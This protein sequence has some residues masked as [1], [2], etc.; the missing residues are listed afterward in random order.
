MVNE[1]EQIEVAFSIDRAE[2]LSVGCLAPGVDV[3]GTSSGLP[4]CLLQALVGALH[5]LCMLQGY[6]PFSAP[7]FVI[8]GLE[9][10]HVKGF[11][12]WGCT[13]R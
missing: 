2:M 12:Q 11:F 8:S 5:Q 3:A 13:S 6:C 1:G 4:E 9:C 7:P 10:I